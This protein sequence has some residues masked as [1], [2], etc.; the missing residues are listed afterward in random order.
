MSRRN[1]RAGTQSLCR[2]SWSPTFPWRRIMSTTLPK[3]RAISVMSTR[4]RRASIRRR[5]ILGRREGAAP[6]SGKGYAVIVAK[7]QV[8][9]GILCARSRRDERA[10][11]S[12]REGIAGY[13]R[14]LQNSPG[15]FMHRHELAGAYDAL[16]AMY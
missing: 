7:N 11:A 10:E 3:A 15:Q 5:T 14:L 4:P 13:E 12:L 16:A 2:R 6:D 8:W 9:Y 1:R